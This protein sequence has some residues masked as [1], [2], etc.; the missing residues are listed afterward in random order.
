MGV[1]YYCLGVSVTPHCKYMYSLLK[2]FYEYLFS[3]PEFNVIVIGLDSSG[4]TVNTI[5]SNANLTRCFTNK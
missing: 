5:F 2:G 4:K 1:T 3:K